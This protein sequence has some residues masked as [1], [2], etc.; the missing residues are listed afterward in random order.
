MEGYNLLGIIQT[1]QQDYM[2][3]S[4]RCRMHSKSILVS[5]ARIT[6]WAMFISPRNRQSR[7]ENEFQAALR[8]DPANAEA[9]Y[10]LGVLLMMKD[11]PAAAIPHFQRVHPATTP[12][13]F[14]LVRAY[15]ADQANRGRSS[16]GHAVYPTTERMCRC[17]SRWECCWL[18]R[19][20]IR[21]PNAVAESCRTAARDL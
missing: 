20:S 1:N 11:S 17:I 10:N 13:L 8:I 19:S 16:R 6:I 21:L 3:P 14:N 5:T 9:N 12:S 2:A 4:H 18:R 7:P 15:F